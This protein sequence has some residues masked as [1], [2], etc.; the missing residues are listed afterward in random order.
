MLRADLKMLETYEYPVEPPLD[1]PITAY[2]GTADARVTVQ[3]LDGWA[4]QTTGTFDVETFPGGHFY[5]QAERQALLDSVVRRLGFDLGSG[6]P[7][8]S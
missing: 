6:D 2:C 4:Q 5:L 7:G 1:C 3:S 8:P